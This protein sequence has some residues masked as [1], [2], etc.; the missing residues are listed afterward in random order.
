MKKQLLSV[1]FIATIL[2][3]SPEKIFAAD[4]LYRMLHADEVESFKADQDAII[5]G[6]L[7]V[8]NDN[9]FT[10][11]VCKVISGTL[12]SNNIAVNS[13]FE[14]GFGN[15][16]LKPEV[17]DYCVM[18]LKKS[19]T[20]YKKAWGIFKATSGDYKTLKLLSEDIKY[21]YCNGDIAAIEWYINSGGV[22]KE[23]SGIGNTVFVN[24][25]N[26]ERLQIYPKENVGV[27][28]SKERLPISGETNNM[29]SF[30]FPYNTLSIVLAF[31]LCLFTLFIL[32][33]NKR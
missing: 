30:R 18:S 20:Y 32:I 1:L 19:G 14:Y 33:K 9:V 31:F 2:L 22:E 8:K 26:G 28:T 10:V 12:K 27:D 15:T 21:P 3:L 11:K 24:R 5:I 17:N 4:A 29:E 16:G 25:P 23:F 6:Q 13:D 7:T